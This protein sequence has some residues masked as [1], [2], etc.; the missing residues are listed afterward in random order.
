VPEPGTWSAAIAI[1]LVAMIALRRRKLPI[2]ARM[3]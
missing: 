3:R 1:G 2:A